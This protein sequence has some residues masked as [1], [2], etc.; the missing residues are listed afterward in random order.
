MAAE[1]RVLGVCEALN[2][3]SDHQAVVIR[4]E[5]GG[6][7]M[8]LIYEGD[9]SEPCLGWPKR[10]FTAPASIPVFGVS[11]AGVFVSRE[12]SR[13][14]FDFSMR[15][16]KAGPA[17]RHTVTVSGVIIRKPLLLSFRGRDGTYIGWGEGLYGG[18]AAVLVLTS[19]PVENPAS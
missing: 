16:R 7:H 13:A 15:V 6:G 2:S 8:T 19:V 1:P 4:G 11:Y 17:A 5:Y 9:P 3:V 12:M 18:C 10:F 14:F